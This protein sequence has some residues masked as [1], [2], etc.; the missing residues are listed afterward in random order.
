[1]SGRDDLRSL[2]GLEQCPLCLPH[3]S[4]Y[5]WTSNHL[6][7]HIRDTHQSHD[8]DTTL[9]AQQLT[10]LY[11]RCIKDCPQCHRCYSLTRS[12]DSHVRGCVDNNASSVSGKKRKSNDNIEEDGEDQ[13]VM[14]QINPSMSLAKRQRLAD[15]AGDSSSDSSE[16]TIPP[17]WLTTHNNDEPTSSDSSDS[18][19]PPSWSIE[20]TDAEHTQNTLPPAG[21]TESMLE[22]KYDSQADNHDQQHSSYQYSP[23]QHSRQQHSPQQHSPQQHSPQ[24]QPSQPNGEQAHP[25]PSEGS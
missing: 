13:L 6:A 19:I 22:S 12:Y 7:A 10:L 4:A 16:S 17:S 23:Q 20:H 3:Q 11:T 21:H 8:Q 1:M 2:G 24:P 14:S 18:T 9:T 15:Q 5:Y 25:T